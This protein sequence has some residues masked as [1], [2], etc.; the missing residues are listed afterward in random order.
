M[1]RN[2]PTICATRSLGESADT[3]RSSTDMSRPIASAIAFSS[4]PPRPISTNTSSG[5]PSS[6]SFMVT[7]AVPTGVRR[8]TVA[9][10]RFCGSGRT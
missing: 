3:M 5:L 7:C 4:L 1:P 6:P 9:P 10:N 8:L 2:W